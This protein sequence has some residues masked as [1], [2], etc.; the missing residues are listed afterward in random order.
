MNPDPRRTLWSLTAEQRGRYGL[1]LVALFV[2]MGL[3]LLAPLAVRVG[4]DEL[5]PSAASRLP[6]RLRDL[7]A[8]WGSPSPL[9]TA[10]WLAAA[11]SLLAAVLS[12]LVDFL[13]GQLAT[14]ASER[15][16][17]RLRERVQRHLDALPCTYHDQ[18]ET[19]DLVQRAT[20][21]VETVRL[22]LSTQVLE[23]GRGT[24]ALV[25]CVPVLFWLDAELAAVSLAL[26][27][28]IVAF[29]VVFFRRIRSLFREADEAEGRMTSALQENLTGA[30]VVRAFSRQAYESERFAAV[31]D[32][33]RARTQRLVETLGLYWGLSDFLCFAQLTLV[34]AFGARAVASGRLTVGDLQVFLA[35]EALTLWPARQLGRV[36]NDAGKAQVALERLGEVLGHAPEDVA[37][38]DSRGGPRPVAVS[39]EARGL[40]FAFTEGEAVLQ[41][42]CFTAPAGSSLAIVGP[43]GAGKSTLLALATRLYDPPPGSLLVDGRDVRSLELDGLRELVGTVPQEPFLDGRSV[44]ENLRVGRPGASEEEL[45]E[46]CRIACVLERVKALPEG[47]GTRVGERGVRLSGGERQRLTLARALLSQAPLLL[48]DDALSAVDVDTEARILDA[49]ATRRPRPTT[50]FVTH[51]LSVAARAVRVVVLEGGRLV[52]EGPPRELRD[53]PGPYRRLWDLQREQA[54]P[55]LPQLP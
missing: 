21:D 42:L 52:Q 32:E 44:A 10:L 40:D 34:L 51:R 33:H 12:G 49:L 13:R 22:F 20:S 37:P 4:L 3:A 45:E 1:A 26:F 28:L 31:N 2:S 39:L 15:I 54:D 7:G 53:A 9:A 50:V 6:D 25:F 17:R 18:A 55:T 23:L 35:C 5:D 41:D 47:L 27:P 14:R 48:F 24:A 38:T 30:R 19:G 46:A 36:L 8:A 43:P 11:G 16:V 29:A